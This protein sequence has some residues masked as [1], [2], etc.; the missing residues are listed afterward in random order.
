MP[1]LHRARCSGRGCG[2]NDT[3]AAV[4]EREDR[5]DDVVP[6]NYVRD[7]G[8]TGPE[9]RAALSEE[10]RTEFDAAWAAAVRHAART[11]DLEPARLLLDRWWSVAALDLTPE[12]RADAAR[13]RERVEAGKET[14]VDWPIEPDPD[15]GI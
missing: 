2:T 12:A 15:E 9:I 8:R 4:T 14:F 13:A 1:P 11:Y 6:V 3:M 10:H 5:D 7:P